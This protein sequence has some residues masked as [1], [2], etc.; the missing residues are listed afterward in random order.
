ML[1]YSLHRN[2]VYT[3]GKAKYSKPRAARGNEAWPS[4]DQ[5][6][7][8]FGALSTFHLAPPPPVLSARLE[9]SVYFLFGET[10]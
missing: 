6:N 8:G 5:L 3:C 4:L 2:K 7:G 1:E 10:V 9:K